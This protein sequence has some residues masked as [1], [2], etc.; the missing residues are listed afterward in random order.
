MS[1]PAVP[2]LGRKERTSGAGV[3][4]S[5]ACHTAK[6]CESAGRG[7][8]GKAAPRRSNRMTRRVPG[9]RKGA[10]RIGGPRDKKPGASPWVVRTETAGALSKLAP[11]RGLARETRGVR[12]PPRPGAAPAEP[13]PPGAL[14]SPLC[15]QGPTG[16]G[17]ARGG[18]GPDSCQELRG[19]LN[20]GPDRSSPPRAAPPRDAHLARKRPREQQLQRLPLQLHQAGVA[21]LA[22]DAAI[23]PGGGAAA[24]AGARGAGA[25]ARRAA[26]GARR[27]GANARGGGARR[28]RK[29]ARG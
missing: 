12:P 28:A 25:E 29:G 11:H 27:A 6:V 1:G 2:A 23:R 15:R 21:V 24:A 20:P 7:F 5:P 26:Q 9:A 22:P 10:L 3:T 17:E 19:C 4:V 18:C 16:R 8:R 13:A 14:S